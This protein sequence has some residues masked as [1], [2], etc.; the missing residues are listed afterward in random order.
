MGKQFSGSS[1][2][3]ERKIHN[4]SWIALKEEK[5]HLPIGIEAALILTIF[6]S[7]LYSELLPP[8]CPPTFKGQLVKYSY[9]ITVGTQRVN[10]VTKLLSVPI[11]VL[12]IQGKLNV[13]H[14][15]GDQLY[16]FCNTFNKH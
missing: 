10:S 2:K 8:D 3:F 12:V 9:K 1:F 4:G 11:R 16:E 13:D 14:R 15:Q 7:D 5:N 6:V